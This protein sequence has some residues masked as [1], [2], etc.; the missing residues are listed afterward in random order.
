M[1]LDFR[2]ETAVQEPCDGITKDL[3]KVNPLEVSAFPLWCHNYRLS[4]T[5]VGDIPVAE[6]CLYY[7]DHLHPLGGDRLLLSRHLLKPLLEV[8]R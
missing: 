3:Y 4:G 1:E 8:F 2:S 6:C 7:G 5:L